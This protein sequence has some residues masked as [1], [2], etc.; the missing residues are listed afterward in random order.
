MIEEALRLVFAGRDLSLEV[1]DRALAGFAP[2]PE[3]DE[4]AETSWAYLDRPATIA[5]FVLL[6]GPEDR[7]DGDEVRPYA[8]QTFSGS[9]PDQILAGLLR[10]IAGQ[11]FTQTKLDAAIGERGRRPIIAALISAHQAYYGVVADAWRTVEVIADVDDGKGELL[12]EIL[13]AAV[14]L[15]RRDGERRFIEGVR[16]G[17]SPFSIVAQQGA[18][19]LRMLGHFY[20]RC[21]VEHRSLSGRLAGELLRMRFSRTLTAIETLWDLGANFAARAGID[22]MT[23][24]P[25]NP[26]ALL[27]TSLDL[28][29][30]YAVRDGFD[31]FMSWRVDRRW[32]YG[33]HGMRLAAHDL[34]LRT[35]SKLTPVSPPT[36]RYKRRFDGLP[37]GVARAS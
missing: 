23:P 5:S 17:A 22:L 20:D 8:D 4:F 33:V 16:A 13:L 14:A 1:V 10:D 25:S 36:A 19:A 26:L 32:R 12:P 31:L 29:P 30:R 24:R 3:R 6:A 18:F 9:L 28:G 21:T 27:K 7:M 11:R 15:T 35:L 34:Q 2:F 37:G